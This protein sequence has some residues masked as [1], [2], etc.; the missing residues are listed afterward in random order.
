MVEI[1]P[2][3]KFVENYGYVPFKYFQ[4]VMFFLIIFTFI[5]KDYIYEQLNEK[6]Y[7]KLTKLNIHIQNLIKGFISIFPTLIILYYDIQFHSFSMKNLGATKFLRDKYI[8]SILR[9][10]GA[11]FVVQMA[12]QDMGI[13]TGEIQAQIP[14]IPFI[15]FLIATGSAYALTSDRSLA[16][17]AGIMYY[18]IK[19]FTR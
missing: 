14:K 12:T 10:F 5:Y 3:D 8:N 13:L 11:Y 4:A 9:L 7:S 16:I 1:I 18:Q 19:F 15:Q 2:S 6:L 17:L